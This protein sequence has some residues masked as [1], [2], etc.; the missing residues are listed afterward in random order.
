MPKVSVI[1][2]CYNHG[3]FLDEAVDS[4][5]AQT[6][7]DF[8]IIV[9]D[10]GSTEE[11]TVRL[12]AGYQ[13]PRT[14]VLHT[15]NQGLAAARNHGIRAAAGEYILPLDADDRI[16]QA[17]LEK[18]VAILDVRPEVGIVYC[19]AEKFGDQTGPWRLPDFSIRKM[20]FSNLIFC[21]AFFRKSDWELVG[22]YRTN[23]KS[24]WEDWD[25][26]LSLLEIGREVDKIPE[27]QFFY[28]TKETSM[29]KAMDRQIRVAMHHQL[30]LNH[31]RLYIG[32][33]TPLLGLYYMIID[34]FPYRC[35]KKIG[36]TRR[37]ANWWLRK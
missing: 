10:D 32:Q 9:V 3:A 35:L 21:S 7:Q 28:R 12:L 8:E 27:V 5:L 26:W 1:V 30:M 33:V 31:P 4:V 25:F 13:R 19:D 18:A 11:A 6:Y 16:N 2:P 14:R 22:G 15:V 36:F 23:M 20:L 37:S 34:S 17:Y 29:I 24:G